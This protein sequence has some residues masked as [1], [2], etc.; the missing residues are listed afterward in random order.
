[1][2]YRRAIRV[3]AE[4]LGCEATEEAV[5]A[6]RLATD[7]MAYAAVAPARDEHGACCSSTTASRRRRSARTGSELGALAGCPAHPGPADRAVSPPDGASATRCAGARAAGFVA[8]KTIA[9]YR[10]GL[11]LERWRRRC[12]R[13]CSPRSRR[14]RRPAIRCPSRSTPGFGDADLLLPLRAARACLKPLIERFDATT[15]RAPALL[16][17]RARGGLARARVRRT[18]SSTSRSR[19]RT[20]RGP[21]TALAE[22]L[23]L[24]PGVQAAVRVGRRPHAGALPAGGALVARRA[25]RRAARAAPGADAEDAARAILR[26]NARSLYRLG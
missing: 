17:V 13:P 22:A 23:E 10:G 12:A 19:S 4:H 15:V 5:H 18:C 9:A 21:P 16:P 24:A 20:S 8:L 25:R 2:T 6:R 7:P 26:D 1:M 3:L 11:D 14:T